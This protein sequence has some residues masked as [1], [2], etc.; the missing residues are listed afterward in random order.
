MPSF[1]ADLVQEIKFAKKYFDYIEITLNPDAHLSVQKIARLKQVLNGFPII[2]HIHWK[3]DFTQNSG[4][5]KVLKTISDFKNLGA[6]KII[7]HPI[8]ISG[9]VPKRDIESNA[10]A[11]RKFGNFC[12]KARVSL[13]VENTP[14]HP[15]NRAKDFAK[16]LKDSG[17]KV[18]LDIGHVF[19]ISCEEL[20]CFFR[21]FGRKITHIHLH[22]NYGKIDHLPF[23]NLRKLHKTCKILNYYGYADSI[24]LEMYFQKRKHRIKMRPLKRRKIILQQL[25]LLKK[26]LG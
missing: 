19:Q 5:K 11:L 8:K 18:A 20:P 17:L 4:F 13:L 14:T 12:K 26:Y 25:I 24:T 9:A 22:N 7:I 6:K 10:N 3:V 15:F 21:S 2:G 1:E 23:E 16:L